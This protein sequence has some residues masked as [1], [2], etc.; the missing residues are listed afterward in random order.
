[1]STGLSR[2][3]E[4]FVE[5]R[6]SELKAGFF[7]LMKDDEFIKSI[8]YGPNGPDRVKY[9]FTKSRHMFKEVFGA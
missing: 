4:H 9:R 8:T 2:Y 6:A 7:E 5:A 3:P 1:M